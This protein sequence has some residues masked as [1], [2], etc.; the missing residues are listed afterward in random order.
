MHSSSIPA[1]CAR[2]AIL[3]PIT[4]GLLIGLFTTDLGLA[5]A[6]ASRAHVPDVLL[7]KFRS[8]LDHR[9]RASARLRA[10]IPSGLERA[11]AIWNRRTSGA[12][13]GG[14]DRIYEIRVPR[15]T[16]VARLASRL[17][18]LPE[19]EYAEPRY[20]YAL[21]EGSPPGMMA[22][23][24]DPRYATDQAY[25]GLIQA[26][27]AWDVQKS[28]A[29]PLVCVVDGGTNWQHED[30]LANMWANPGEIAGNG[31]DDDGNGFIDDIH[32][33]DFLA[34]DGD[35]RGS[36]STPSN[37]NHGTHTA[38][39]LAAVTHNAVGMA[40]ASWNPRL[41]AVNASH[42][43]DQFIAY[44]FEGILYAVDN[45][46]AIV[47]LSWGGGQW[48]QFGKDVIDYAVAHGVLVVA[49]A[50][51]QGPGAPL[52]VYPGAYPNVYSVVNVQHLAP[53]ADKKHST[54]NSGTW[55]DL[56]AP[57]TSIFSTVDNGV[58]NAYASFTGT[59]MATPIAA[60]VAALIKARHPTWDGL[61]VG[62][63]L[64][65][66]C[67]NIDGLNSGLAF[68]LGKGRINALRALTQSPPSVR[69]TGWTFGDADGNGQLNRGETV[70]MSLDL[71]NYRASATNLQ[72]SL[73]STTSTIV[74]TDGTEAIASLAEDAT[75]SLPAA[76]S[77]AV[78]SSTF[79]GASFPLRIGMSASGGY[80]DF[81]WIDVVVE[82]LYET[83]DINRL[84]ASFTSTGGIGWWGFA[85][86]PGGRKGEGVR[87][88]GGP[89][90]LFEGGFMVGTDA[91]HLADAIRIP[92]FEGPG[93]NSDFFP[94]EPPPFRLTPGLVSD[95]EIRTSFREFPQV[96]VGVR[97]QGETRAFA[98]PANQDFIL[99]GYRVVNTNTTV[100]TGL[101]VGLWLDWNIDESY[102]ATNRADW[103]AARG[104]GYAW[105]TTD[106][107]QPYFGVMVLSG[108]S[109]TT[110]SALPSSSYPK[111]AKWNAM[112]GLFGTSSGPGDVAH[113]L[114]TGPFNVAPGDSVAVWFA[115][116]A[117]H[118]LAELQ[119]SADQAR[120]LWNSLVAVEQGPSAAG[121]SLAKLAPNPFSGGTRLDLRIDRPRTLAASV[122][123]TRGRR[124]RNLGNRAFGAGFASLEW[125]GKDDGGHAVG[126]GVYFLSVESEGQR[127]MKKAIVLR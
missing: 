74:V 15:G 47:S 107:S 31:L 40:S 50:G 92:F 33:W 5:A 32:G 111:T 8:T 13:A 121:M 45:G 59:S 54:S 77:F 104:L 76:F 96:F 106:L 14:I 55:V 123:D 63:Q 71:H 26:P 17:S 1:T 68:Q 20:L 61:K 84:H 119:A 56:C 72:L 124:V 114:A 95:Q 62:E 25:L 22:V 60:A 103:D 9:L 66:T 80:T 43:F 113:V 48:S 23:P 85:T 42:S 90:C 29:G 4:C 116:I 82:P 118:S 21:F 34:N 91:D 94:N 97:V 102:F 12:V 87:F 24:N 109:S 127:W 75:V 108:G 100:L 88:D 89:N 30:L 7:V 79:I 70:T 36:P 126:A 105:D 110:Y 3:I 112:N 58:N 16:D 19:V 120:T 27:S 78:S 125:D 6:D 44:G 93:E 81:Q 115:L 67:D 53:N 99:A 49:A 69:L 39:L 46:A 65:A 10:A 57:G 28:N 2:R 37:A 117:G 11:R 122:F 35:P 101:R 41:M 18:A 98:A 38:G 51:N 83:H 86:E 52:I 64:R 73:I